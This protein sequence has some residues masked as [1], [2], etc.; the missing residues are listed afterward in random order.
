[1][2][3]D[4]NTLVNDLQRYMMDDDAYE[5]LTPLRF[6]Q[7]PGVPPFLNYIVAP[8][9]VPLHPPPILRSPINQPQILSVEHV[10]L[11]K[12]AFSCGVTN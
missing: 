12:V 7:F 5:E 10:V 9:D 1:M 11:P 2:N 3:S 4:N 6:S 8:G